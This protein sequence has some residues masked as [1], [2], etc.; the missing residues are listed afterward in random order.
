MT[1]FDPIFGYP[2]T[3]WYTWFAWHPVDTVDRGWRW[4]VPVQRRR[5]QKKL[6]LD[7]GADQWFQH[8]VRPPK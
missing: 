3:D 2:L 5:I 8:A 4:L 6:N 1:S 7:G